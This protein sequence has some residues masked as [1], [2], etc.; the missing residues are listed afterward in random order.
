M[1]KV[2]KTKKGK[3]GRKLASVMNRLSILEN[4]KGRDVSSKERLSESQDES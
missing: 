1:G 2:N 4:D 3:E